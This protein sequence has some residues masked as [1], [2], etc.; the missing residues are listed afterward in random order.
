MKRSELKKI[1][2]QMIIE[3]SNETPLDYYKLAT[4]FRDFWTDM[5][6]D[7]KSSDDA[8]VAFK[9]LNKDIKIDTWELDKAF[10]SQEGIDIQ[11]YQVP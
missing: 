5:D 8:L 9:K 6:S 11:S 1:I 2:K 4:Q 3:E 7:S 10:E